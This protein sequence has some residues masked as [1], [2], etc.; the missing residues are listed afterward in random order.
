MKCES[1]EGRADPVH[2]ISFYLERI[3]KRKAGIKN[4]EGIIW[5][6]KSDVEKEIPQLENTFKAL[7]KCKVHQIIGKR[8]KNR[9]IQSSLEKINTLKTQK[10]NI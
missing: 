2:L 10:H 6:L 5:K 9:S 3:K 7:K 4:E 1:Q 8:Y